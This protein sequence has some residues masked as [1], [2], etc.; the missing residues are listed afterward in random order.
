[1]TKKELREQYLSKRKGLTSQFVKLESLKI[2]DIFSQNFEVEN[3]TI[4]CFI[5]IEKNN[6]IDTWLLIDRIM[7]KGRVVVPKANFA[8][9][10]M[11][12]YYFE[13]DTEL[14]KNNYGILEPVSAEP[15]QIENIEVVLL[16]L[17]A[18]DKKG[19]RVG[20]GGGF[21]DRFI[22]QLPDTTQLI[23]LSLFDSVDEIKDLDT[24]DKKMGACITPTELYYFE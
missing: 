15:C 12:H 10:S 17:L 21:Y 14:V 18:F 22:A 11:S 13:K 1:M 5:P 20:Y 6:E 2:T 8:D 19:F 4:H 7:E 9:N 23:G 24:F 16:P 3:K